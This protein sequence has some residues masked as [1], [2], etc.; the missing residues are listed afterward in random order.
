MTQPNRKKKPAQA[1]ANRTA[2]EIIA[3]NPTRRSRSERAMLTLTT[4]SYPH[5]L[6]GNVAH[7][8]FAGDAAQCK[9]ALDIENK[10]GLLDF[11]REITLEG[12]EQGLTFTAGWLRI[13]GSSVRIDNQLGNP[14][15]KAEFKGDLTA[16]ENLRQDTSLAQVLVDSYHRGQ[17]RGMTRVHDINAKHWKMVEKKLTVGSEGGFGGLGRTETV[18]EFTAADAIKLLNDTIA[19]SKFGIQV[20][21]TSIV[22]AAGESTLEITYVVPAKN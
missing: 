18:F 8:M 22:I 13:D 21:P 11:I 2:A 12:N 7:S 14:L 10:F 4:S 3:A 6:L 20:T 19:S 1:P 16:L 17:V 15:T 5:Y 9:K